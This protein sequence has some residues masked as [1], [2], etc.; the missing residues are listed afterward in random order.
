M[1]A[2]YAH[3][4][5]GVAASWPGFTPP[6]STPSASPS[7][8]AGFP[9]ISN[10]SSVFNSTGFN[11]TDF[12]TQP[13]NAT[14][15]GAFATGNTSNSTSGVPVV[16]ET[17]YVPTP[18]TV[19]VPTTETV[20]VPATTAPATTASEVLADPLS[21]A[22]ASVW[23]A[24][25]T[26]LSEI[27]G[28]EATPWPGYPTAAVPSVFPYRQPQK[29]RG[30]APSFPQKHAMILNITGG[31]AGSAYSGTG[32]FPHG[33]T[34]SN[35][36]LSQNQ[37]NGGGYWGTLGAP[38]LPYWLNGTA[39]SATSSTPWGNMTANN[40]NP[41]TTTPDTNTTRKYEW[42]ISYMDIAPDGVTKPG[43]VVN[44]QFPGKYPHVIQP[45]LE[46]TTLQV[47]FLKQTG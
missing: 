19:F 46:L 39:T 16:T 41:Y 30:N 15:S 11:S 43:L 1:A 24:F 12:G 18:E 31:S 20:F 32:F 33:S 2:Q 3:A 23:S 26:V 13:Q 27:G 29:S 22:K 40:T 45:S 4:I 34:S 14:R 36:S 5:L 25:S 8:S 35:G 38:T 10:S 44:G 9:Q 17:V 37:T 42:T 7:P 28:N 6:V 21:A 47:R